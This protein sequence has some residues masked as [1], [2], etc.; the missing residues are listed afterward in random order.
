MGSL[1]DVKATCDELNQSPPLL[2]LKLND[3]N[4]ILMLAYGMGTA[5]FKTSSE[6][7]DHVIV[8]AAKNA[9]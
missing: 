1:G 9:I 5:N 4:F 7:I 2:S 6:L 3:G 8:E